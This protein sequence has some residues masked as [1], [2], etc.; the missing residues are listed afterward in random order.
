MSIVLCGFPKNMIFKERER[1]RE[2]ERVA[3]IHFV[4]YFAYSAKYNMD[5]V[6]LKS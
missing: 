6:T 1:E 5:L 4:K 2:R 3:T